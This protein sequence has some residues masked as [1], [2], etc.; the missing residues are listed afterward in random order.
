MVDEEEDDIALS[1]AIETIVTTRVG[2]KRK[3][4]PKVVQ[5]AVLEKEL[6]RAK[7]GSQKQ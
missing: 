1:Q 3:A 2:R 7:M 4:T 6:K 5:N